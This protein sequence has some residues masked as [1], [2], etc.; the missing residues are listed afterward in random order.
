MVLMA[1]DHTRDFFSNAVIEANDE[2]KTNIFLFFTR[3]ITNLCA[4]TFIFLVGV[5]M[6]LALK[7]G[8]SKKEISYFLLTRGLWIIIAD[9][10]I[11]HFAWTFTF[12]Y[13][14]IEFDVLFVTGWGMILLALLIFLPRTIIFISCMIVVAGHNILDG[15][16][17]QWLGSLHWLHL[18]KPFSIAIFNQK[19]FIYPWYV[20]LPWI[21]IPGLG[22]VFGEIFDLPS[23]QRAK[24][25]IF[26]GTSCIS[27]FFII[28]YLNIY[29]DPSL[30]LNHSE[31]LRTIFSFLNVT[32]Y[33]PSLLYLLI[34]LGI[35]FFILLAFE[36]FNNKFTD[37]FVTFGRIPFAFYI[38]H[39]FVIHALAL[40]IAY[41]A[42]GSLS[43]KFIDNTILNYDPGYLA[44]FGYGL[45]IVFAIW[46]LVIAIF[47]PFCKWYGAFK[48]KHKDKILLSY[49]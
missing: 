35:A 16:D 1:L 8:K 43:T 17:L 28:R 37:F 31:K 40:G 18:P 39:I 38:L 46:I 11:V 3:W 15:H 5:G 33:P 10:F 14:L 42:F 22:Y 45:S 4:P 24:V 30:W 13:T 34:N 12:N 9:F 32:K 19:I 44:P 6:Y 49:L 48:Q 2:F 25:L 27:L 41:V 47:Y 29:G 26:L 21:V 23:R 20:L 7:S 36:K